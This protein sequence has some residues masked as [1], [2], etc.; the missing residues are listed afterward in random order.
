MRE[1]LSVTAVPSFLR[2]NIKRHPDRLQPL[3]AELFQRIVALTH[4]MT[5]DPT[6][7]IEGRRRALS[8]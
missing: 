8:D 7:P 2:N 6:E 4:G 5:F 3:P 1:D